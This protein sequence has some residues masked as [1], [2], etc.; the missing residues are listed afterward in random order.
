MNLQRPLVLLAVMSLAACTPPGYVSKPLIANDT[1]HLTSNISV[2][3]GNLVAGALWLGVIHLVYDPLAPNWEIKEEKLSEDTYR[4]DLKMKR[5]QTGG[6][7]EVMQVLRRRAAQLQREQ[8]F[9]DYQVVE[10]SEGIESQTLGARR[11]AEALVRF[12]KKPVI[13]SGG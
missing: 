13:V 10:F 9:K 2:G 7:G 1:I 12:Q 3:V 6:G 8:G 4:Y 11:N 5:Y